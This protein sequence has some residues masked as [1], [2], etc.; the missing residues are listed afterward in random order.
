[1]VTLPLDSIP[2]LYYDNLKKEYDNAVK[3]NKEL[4]ERLKAMSM[5]YEKT[6]LEIKALMKVNNNL[7]KDIELLKEE[8]K[9][10]TNLLE[11]KEHRIKNLETKVNDLVKRNDERD[12]ILLSSEVC[13]LYEKIQN[14]IE[15]KNIKKYQL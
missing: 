9:R 13:A 2:R 15:Y 6:Q 3:E 11:E 8:N 7:E 5:D 10:L 1:M 14:K 12:A 4:V